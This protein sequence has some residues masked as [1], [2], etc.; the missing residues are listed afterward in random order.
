M[1]QQFMR[2]PVLTTDGQAYEQSLIDEWFDRRGRRTS[3]S[4]MLEL[5]SL[6]RLPLGLLKAAVEAYINARPEVISIFRQHWEIFEI[7]E[8]ATQGSSGPL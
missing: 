1:S 6:H 3:P 4:T 5:A 7:F 8:P 2:H